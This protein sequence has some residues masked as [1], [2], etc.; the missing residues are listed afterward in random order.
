MP[1]V[2]DDLKEFAAEIEAFFKKLIDRLD[3]DED[4][5][6]TANDMKETA[7][8]LAGTEAVTAE[9]TANPTTGD[10]SSTASTETSEDGSSSESAA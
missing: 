10:S 7:H 2:E 6:E 1:K 5:I 8:A 4:N 3:G 9:D